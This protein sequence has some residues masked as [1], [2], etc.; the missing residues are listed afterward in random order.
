MRLLPTSNEITPTVTLTTILAVFGSGCGI[1]Q[2]ATKSGMMPILHNGIDS[3]IAET[4]LDVAGGAL[5]ANLKLIE[6]VSAT[7][8]D[9]RA[10]LVMVAMARANCAFGFVMDELEAARTAYP[11]DSLRAQ[12]LLAR[13]LIN[14]A[15]GRSFARRALS[16]NDDF[17][18]VV[19][20]RPLEALELDEF[21]QALATLEVEDAAPLF[22]LAFN[23]GGRLMAS[24]DPV[25]ATQLPMIEAMVARVLELDEHVFY[26]AGPNLLAGTLFGF[27]GPALGGSPEKAIQRFDR[28]VELAGQL[29]IADVFKAQYVYAQTERQ[30]EF[31]KTLL[32]AIEAAPNPKLGAFESLAKRKAC[33][34][35]ANLDNY[36][37]ADPKPLPEACQASRRRILSA[38]RSR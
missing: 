15:S 36:F 37:L 35:F 24:Q 3:F 9:E 20:D 26:G 4:D 18:E 16:H 31:E 19:A 12:G 34:L 10:P 28:A 6:G 25:E 8:P 11:D 30:E 21:T 23:W 27:R 13:V 2:S 32:T 33:R 22:W 29:L 5:V 14:F 17:E 1:V 7:Y 38:R